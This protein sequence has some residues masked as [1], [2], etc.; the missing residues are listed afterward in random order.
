MYNVYLCH[1]RAHGDHVEEG[2]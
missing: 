1:V 2:S